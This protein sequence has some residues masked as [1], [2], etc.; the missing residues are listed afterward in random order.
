MPTRTSEEPTGTPAAERELRARGRRT[1]R[2]LL[3]GGMAALAERGFHAT[4]VDDIVRSARTSHGTFYLYFSDKE[5]LVRT[6]AEEC[7]DEITRVVAGL[8]PVD[9]GPAGREQLREWLGTWKDAYER[10][11]PVVRVWMEDHVADPGLMQVGAKA[12]ADI[13]GSLATRVREAGVSHVAPEVAAAAML[14]MTERL[15]YYLLSRGI[16]VD[17]DALLDTLATMAHR[18][19]FGGE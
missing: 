4:R 15:F 16:G 18:A 9:P 6:L 8:E 2:K 19:F 3:D 5:D 12:M 17:D 14:A 1:M 13:T 10:Y 11:G 7:V